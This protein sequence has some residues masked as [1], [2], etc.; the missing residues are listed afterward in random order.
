MR[1]KAMTGSKASRFLSGCSRALLFG[2]TSAPFF[3]ASE[4]PM[5][6]ASLTAGFY[7]R[8]PD[9]CLAPPD[10]RVLR[11]EGFASVEF[12]LVANLS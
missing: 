4:A 10:D 6:M 8:L 9:L 3:R 5:S 12:F 2:G 1:C 7:S 11:D